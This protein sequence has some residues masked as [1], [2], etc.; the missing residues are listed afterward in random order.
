MALLGAA[1]LAALRASSPSSFGSP[2]ALALVGRLPPFLPASG[3]GL[4]VSLGP[5]VMSFQVCINYPQCV[6]STEVVCAK[7]FFFLGGESLHV[8]SL[9]SPITITLPI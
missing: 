6:Y 3:A 1:L 5:A 9:D 4:L 2:A 7:D 8:C